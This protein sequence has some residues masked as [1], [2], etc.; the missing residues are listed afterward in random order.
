MVKEFSP[1]E[2]ENSLEDETSESI[3]ALLALATVLAQ[4][5]IVISNFE[6]DVTFNTMQESFRRKLSE[7]IPDL[8][9]TGKTAVGYGLDRLQKDYKLSDFEIDYSDA[10]FTDKINDVFNQNVDYVL[11]TNRSTYQEILQ[12]ANE[13]GWSGQE[14]AR[15]LKQMYGLIPR[16]VNT[17]LNYER[18]LQSEG[19]SKK[20]ITDRVQKRIDQLVEWRYDLVSELISTGVVEESKE[21]SWT[22]LGETNQLDTSQYVKQWISVI[23]SVSSSVCI[24]AHHTT[25]EIG[26]TFPNGLTSPPNTLLP[27]PCRSSMRIIRRINI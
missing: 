5:K 17:V 8:N 19:L 26:G 27:H 24:E 3:I 18:A 10:R 12:V 2:D 20:V 13:R 7:I 14:I 23:D 15:R 4:N 6:Y 25:A 9:S 11:D 22:I 1:Y 21:V 16:H